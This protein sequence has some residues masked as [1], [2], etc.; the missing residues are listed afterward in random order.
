MRKLLLLSII[1]IIICSSSIFASPFSDVPPDHWSID[2]I[3]NLKSKGIMDG[4]ADNT[5]KG[6]KVVSRYHLAMVLSKMLANVEQKKGTV[7]KSDLKVIERLTIEFADEL[8]LMNIKVKSLEDDLNNVKENVSNIKKDVKYLKDF[9]KNG[10]NDKVKISGDIVVRNHGYERKDVKNTHRT[11]TMF[12]IQLDTKLSEKVEVHSR[13]NIIQ[14]NNDRNMP[15]A[16]NQW[17][18]GNKNTGDVEIAYLK[19]KNIFEDNGTIKIGRDWYTHGHGLVIHDY[20]DT[21]S[22]SKRKKSLDLAF[23]CFF[24]RNN[25]LTQKD[26]LNI[27]NINLDYYYKNHKLYLGFYFNKR[28]WAYNTPNTVAKIN[29]NA[30]DLRIEFGSSGRINPKKEAL[31]YDLAGVYNKSEK[32]AKYANTET[33]LKGWLSYFAIKYDRKKD[34]SFKLA[35]T[36]ADEESLAS[37]KRNDFNSYCLRE[38]T[39]FDDLS[40]IVTNGMLNNIKNYKAQVEYKFKKNT[41]HS[42]RLAYDKIEEK[43]SNTFQTDTNLITFEYRY[44]ISENTRLRVVY[45]NS[46][47]KEGYYTPQNSNVKLYLTEIYTRF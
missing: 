3:N 47:D 25:S 19:L 45:Q 21:I 30:N 10:G 1:L 37:I 39:P 35:Y 43:N 27:W 32:F 20:M 22:Y 28:D 40:L 17:N 11:E 18:G 8:S 12:R 23:N 46:K 44:Q 31:T 5:F 13:W 41:K 34:L 24:D 36:Y 33:N 9:I 4:Y 7:S 2:A 29:K 16:T 26:Y 14:H 15:F 6:N 42:L 38:E